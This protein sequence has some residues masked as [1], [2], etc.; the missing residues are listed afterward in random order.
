M[1]MSTRKANESRSF[2]AYAFFGANYLLYIFVRELESLISG[3]RR[4]TTAIF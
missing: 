3:I 2:F 4:F 1:T